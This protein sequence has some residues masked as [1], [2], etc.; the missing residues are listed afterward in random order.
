MSPHDHKPKVSDQRERTAQNAPQAHSPGRPVPPRPSPMASP[1]FIGIPLAAATANDL[2]AAVNRLRSTANQ[3]AASG[4]LRW[5]AP[6]SWHI[7]LQFLGQLHDATI[8]TALSP[9]CA[10]CTST[11]RLHRARDT[12]HLRSRRSPLRRCP[13]LATTPRAPAGRH[14]R[15]RALRLHPGNPSL[16][17]PHHAGAPEREERRQRIPPSAVTNQSVPALLQL[18][19]R[20]LRPLRKHPHAARLTLRSPRTIHDCDSLRLAPSFPLRH[21]RQ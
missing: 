5:S 14:R 21:D 7:T 16:P 4:N 6:E 8:S 3:R 12:R 13:R 9:A 18:H 2:T 19:R 17:S 15:H 20:L 1:L 11:A 10:R